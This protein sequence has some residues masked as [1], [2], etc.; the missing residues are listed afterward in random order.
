MSETYKTHFLPD[1][2][3]TKILA[4]S[5]AKSAKK[6]D[7]FFLKGDL[8]VGKTTFA[9]YFIRFFLCDNEVVPSP[10]FTLIQ[11]YD[12]KDF[13]LWHIDLYRLENPEETRELGLEEIFEN[14]VCLIE[15]PER[16]M[17]YAPEKR[18]D[19][20]FSQED[21]ARQVIVKYLNKHETH[22]HTKI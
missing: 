15:W 20:S 6:G 14:G 7:I 18:I 10:T 5:L 13:P 19:L 2:Q 8:G 17:S 1:E 11:S 21:E 22:E 16:M 12:T 4:E 3:H 9:R